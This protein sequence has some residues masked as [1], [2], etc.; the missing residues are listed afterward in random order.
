MV[1]KALF[2]FVFTSWCAYAVP[3]SADT[4]VFDPTG[5]GGVGCATCTIDTFDW[6]PGNEITLNG[7]GATA[8]SVGQSVQSLFQANLNTAD[9]STTVQTEYTN[10]SNGTFFTLVAGIPEVISA[11]STA[12]TIDFDL[13]GGTP[14]APNGNNYFYIYATT[15]S[16]NILNGSVPNDRSGICF[17][18]GTLILSGVFVD[19]ISFDNSFTVNQNTPPPGPALDQFGTNN[20]AGITSLTG[21]GGLVANVRVTSASAAYFPGL[22]SGTIVT[23]RNQ[24]QNN[25][26]FTTVDPSACF[27]RDGL[28]AMLSCADA[29]ATAGA[30]GA[31]V[32][33]INGEGLDVMLQSD[34]STSFTQQ[35]TAVPEPA[36]LTLLGLG[37][38][39]VAARRRRQAKSNT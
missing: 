15:N 7:G 12:T 24:S 28:G 4:I 29:G 11:D 19:D 34:A 23:F 27:N 14:A 21:T 9:L 32:G 18:C 35:Q 13:A 6:K 36:S 5:G 38:A 17:T 39:G 37:L 31:G 26:P 30:G 3:A 10:G 22:T 25:L 1:R 20:Y 2:M 33:T 16:T 8:Q